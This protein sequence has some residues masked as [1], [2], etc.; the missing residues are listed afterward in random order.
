[1]GYYHE[2]IP[3]LKL[4]IAYETP[5]VENRNSYG[6]IMTNG[7]KTLDFKYTDKIKLKNLDLLL[8]HDL[9]NKDA[10]CLNLIG[11]ITFQQ[12]NITHISFM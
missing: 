11:G 3:K 12:Y 4:G 6:V 2:F 9:L 7:T 10:F 1:M 8:M 5:L